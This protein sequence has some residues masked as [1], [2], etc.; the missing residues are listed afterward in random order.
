MNDLLI[1][2]LPANGLEGAV[3]VAKEI[4]SEMGMKPDEIRLSTG[5]RVSYNWQDVKALEH[6]E[7]SEVAYISKNKI[8]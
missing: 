1:Y 4:Y 3:A 7:M 5:E 2:S 6:G 8:I